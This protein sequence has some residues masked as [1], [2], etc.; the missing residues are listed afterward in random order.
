MYYPLKYGLI[1]LISGIEEVD[2]IK[3]IQSLPTYF[4]NES[5]FASSELRD[6]QQK[7]KTGR[8]ERQLCEK[9]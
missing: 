5:Y 1:S 6:L 8:F 2:W 4:D 3:S 7:I 9:D